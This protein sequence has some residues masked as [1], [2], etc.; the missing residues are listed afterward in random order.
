MNN[1][2]NIVLILLFFLPKKKT[3]FKKIFGLQ[4]GL[5]WPSKNTGQVMGQP[6]FTLGKK[7]KK[8]SGQVFFRSS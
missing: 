2:T 8:G 5:G 1:L 4:G 3:F 6:V 7:K